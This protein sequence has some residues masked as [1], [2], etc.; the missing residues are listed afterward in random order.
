MNQIKS[1]KEVNN[2]SKM[3]MPGFSAEYSL[4]ERN[5]NY[6]VG[7]DG[8]LE[9]NTQ[10]VPQMMRRFWEEDQGGGGSDYPPRFV[11]GNPFGVKKPRV[12]KCGTCKRMPEVGPGLWK[13]CIEGDGTIDLV[14]C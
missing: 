6:Y 4:Y 13:T 1:E 2:M 14:E 9:T 12:P 5:R 10:V 7:A 3:S 11:W 8:S